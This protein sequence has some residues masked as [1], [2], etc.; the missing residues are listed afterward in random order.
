MF[1][2]PIPVLVILILGNIVD[3]SAVDE[4]L[5]D[6]NT[7]VW[8]QAKQQ[9]NVKVIKTTFGEQ[10]HYEITFAGEKPWPVL[11]EKFTVNKD[12]FGGGFVKALQAD[13]D[14]ELEILAWGW[15]EQGQSFLLD[16][17][18]GHISKETFDRAPAEVQK[19]AMD[20]YEAYMSGGMTITLVGM[21]CFVYYMLVAVVYA[22]VRIVRRIRSINLAN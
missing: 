21:L 8:G 5:S 7:L 9:L 20:W 22:V 13:S 18:E 10:D 19:S 1:L 3:R 16:F 4:L 17:S 15:H 12:M 6:P 11:I 14:A 2:W